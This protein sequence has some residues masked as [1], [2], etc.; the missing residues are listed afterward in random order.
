MTLRPCPWCGRPGALSHSN[1]DWAH[2]DRL[3]VV[4]AHCPAWCGGAAFQAPVVDA[5][6]VEAA[7][8]HAAWLWNVRPAP[9]AVAPS[10]PDSD[11]QPAPAAAP[12]A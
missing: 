2:H 4:Y 7:E 11:G 9:P 6:R 1:R 12:A 10:G 8:T 3:W 5:G